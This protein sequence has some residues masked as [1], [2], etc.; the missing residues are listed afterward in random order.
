MKAREI[1]WQD[2]LRGLELYHRLPAGARRLFVEKV[3]PS[4]ALANAVLGEWRQALL[5]SGLMVSGVRGVN[6]SVAPQ[7]MGFCRGMRSLRRNRI[8]DSP[9]RETLQDFVNEHLDS[10]E[11][12]AFYGRTS[13]FYYRD[14]DGP[15][16]LYSRVCSSEW[17]KQFLAAKDADWE[18]KYQVKG[19]VAYFPS[20]E[21]L[22]AA[23]TLVQKLIRAAAPVPM[24][25]LQRMCPELGP[26]LLASAI[27]AGTRYLLFF[28]AVREADLDPVLGLWPAIARKLSGTASAPPVPVAVSQD[29]H[30]PFLMEDMTKILAA[31]AVNPLRSRAGDF[32]LFE[33]AREDLVTVLESLPGW[34]EGEFQYS[35]M[36][37]ISMALAFLERFGFLAKKGRLGKDHRMEVTESGSGWSGLRGKDRLKAILDKLQGTT[38]ERTSLSDEA[39]SLVPDVVSMPTAAQSGVIAS[40]LIAPFAGLDADVFVRLRDFVDYYRERSNPLVEIRRKGKDATFLIGGF[41]ISAPSAEEMEEAWEGALAEFQ[42][43]LLP[44]GGVKLGRDNGG[45]VCFAMTGAGRY[46]IGAAADFDLPG[47]APGRI[48]VQP[49]FDIVFLAP[50]RKAESEIA[51]FC[52]RKGRHVGTLFKVT[53]QSILAAAAAGLTRERVLEMLREHCSA[54]LPANVEF[55]ITGWFGQ[56]SQIRVCPALLIYCP[57]T[58]TAVRVVAAAGKKVTRLNET[59]LELQSAKEQGSL[60]R[61]LREAGIFTRT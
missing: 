56:Y 2:F 16:K 46:V 39:I 48:V 25:E 19:A 18:K 27:R 26:G 3:Q 49:N 60:L 33:S 17:L 1:D 55:E 12:G 32:E 44:L 15:Q 34:V 51:R 7:L 38:K 36:D 4:Q 52:E 8:L 35:P 10:A 53:K 47:E 29:F 5:D 59:T 40:A 30:S 57:D 24:T 20:A 28:P 22:R 14:Y 43:R 50:S 6:A 21:I 61:K 31:C 58:E 42:R 37:R 9:S 11:V 23:Q 13:D 54:E 41:H 45:A